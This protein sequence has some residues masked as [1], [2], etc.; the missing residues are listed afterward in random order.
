MQIR[1]WQE[2]RCLLQ[3]NHAQH[4]CS[5]V[6][7]LE[8]SSFNLRCVRELGSGPHL[9]LSGGDIFVTEGLSRWITNRVNDRGSSIKSCQNGLLCNPMPIR[10]LTGLTFLSI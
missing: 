8:T 1:K 7:S 6:Q 4:K 2:A 10:C 9:P 3:M 5:Q